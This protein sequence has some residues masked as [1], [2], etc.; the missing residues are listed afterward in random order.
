MNS[1]HEPA[2]METSYMLLKL[3]KEID[4]LSETKSHIQDGMNKKIKDIDHKIA[5]KMELQAQILAWNIC[6]LHVI[7]KTKGSG[8]YSPQKCGISAIT[9]T[10]AVSMMT[11]NIL[12]CVS[13]AVSASSASASSSTSMQAQIDVDEDFVA[14]VDLIAASVMGEAMPSR[15]HV[16]LMNSSVDGISIVQVKISDD[17]TL[18]H[19]ANSDTKTDIM[20]EQQVVAPMESVSISELE[21][22][23]C[24]D[25]GADNDDKHV[26]HD[27]ALGIPEQEPVQEQQISTSGEGGIH[28]VNDDMQHANVNQEINVSSGGNKQ[29][30]RSKANV[31]KVKRKIFDS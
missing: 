6:Y 30:H 5:M 19:V 29:T 10:K 8:Y 3:K 26:T 9:P 22:V 24:T 12:M 7:E 11:G 28:V 17:S 23:T 15:S 13:P 18:A 21:I 14:D 4:A 2:Y 20:V 31:G 25:D 1:F 27:K 16:H